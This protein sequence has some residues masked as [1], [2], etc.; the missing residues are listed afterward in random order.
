ME[1]EPALGRRSAERA[2]SPESVRY[3]VRRVS[4]GTQ[5]RETRWTTAAVKPLCDDVLFSP[6]R[7]GVKRMARLPPR[8]S[9]T[10]THNDVAVSLS[11]CLALLVE[12]RRCDGMVAR[13]CSTSIHVDTHTQLPMCEGEEGAL[14]AGQVKQRGSRVKMQ[15]RKEEEEESGR[16][17]GQQM[18]KP[19][20]NSEER[21]V[22][23]TG[24]DG[25]H[26]RLHSLEHARVAAPRH[27]VLG[28]RSPL[29]HRGPPADVAPHRSASAQMQCCVLPPQQEEGRRR[30]KAAAAEQQSNTGM[31]RGERRR[32]GGGV[33][34]SR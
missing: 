7:G 13:R 33:R 31:P 22:E 1:P 28:R 34:L 14:S 11:Q 19:T 8:Y 26:I 3:Y 10:H 12:Q 30:T 5:R 29:R 6:V 4:R 18:V 2:P 23:E 25:G 17:G 20:C 16:R 27:T 21:V 9:H 24:G 32:W 15:R